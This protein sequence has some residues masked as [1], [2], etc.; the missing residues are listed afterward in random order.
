MS[1]GKELWKAAGAR[2]AAARLHAGFSSQRIFAEAVEA[3]EPTIA[4]YEQGARE[5]PMWLL[6]WLGEHH[7]INSGWIV[8]GRGDMIDDP[9]KAPPPS[10]AVDPWAMAR[11]W[12]VIERIC[13]ETGRTVTGTQIA[14]EA[15]ILYSALLG[16][17][18]DVRDRPMVEAALA[19]LG[20]EAKERML[21]VE[22][23]TGKRSAS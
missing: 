15:A 20:E 19:V 5:I 10:T 17:I 2:L 23:G 22:P 9:S 3:A 11:A 7:G 14:E 1:K 6:V 18:V 13:R 12:A 16:R 4:K 21:Q 8:S